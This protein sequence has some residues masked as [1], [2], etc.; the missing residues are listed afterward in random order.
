M[1]S[2]SFW[3]H[4]EALR[5]T[6]FAIAFT[7]FLGFILAFFCQD[8]LF[9]LLFS[10]LQKKESSFSYAPLLYQRVTAKK[11]GLYT[12]PPQATILSANGATL[13]EKGYV[14][15]VG[16]SLDYLIPST[17]FL[18]LSPL[19]GFLSSLKLSF[20]TGFL[21]TSPIWLL[22]IARF[23]L[24][25]LYPREKRILWLCLPLFLLFLLGGMSFGY[26]ITLPLVTRFF[27]EFTTIGHPSWA[28]AQTLDFT[29]GLLLA[30]GLS[31]ECFALL[32]VLV[33]FNIVK[34]YHLAKGRRYV[35]VGIFILAA[36]FTPP[37]VLSQLLLAGPLIVLFE[38]ILLFGKLRSLSIRR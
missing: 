28:L 35:V 10:P 9:R 30:H 12:P 22:L 29:L 1:R 15:A 25:A 33:Y 38:G 20:W 18:L 11:E 32:F 2:D 16:G 21:G 31:F 17:P 5:Q 26:F 6:L 8:L 37:D 36:I 27:Q 3:G 7:L 24:P 4:V 23:C 14:I 13:Q 19:E 34:P